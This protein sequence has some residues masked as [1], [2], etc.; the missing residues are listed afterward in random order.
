[1]RPVLLLG[2]ATFIVVHVT[3]LY[4]ALQ[5][6]VLDI[7]DGTLPLPAGPTVWGRLLLVVVELA[8]TGVPAYLFFCNITQRLSYDKVLAMD[9]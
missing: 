9:L 7:V 5:L 2:F 1:M 3:V 8:I 6:L 4:Q